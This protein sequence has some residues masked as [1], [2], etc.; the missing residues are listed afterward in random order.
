MLIDTK[1]S[2][3]K[4]IKYRVVVVLCTE[5]YANPFVLL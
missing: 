3:N 2:I 1:D 5:N 4:N